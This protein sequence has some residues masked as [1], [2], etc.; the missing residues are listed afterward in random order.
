MGRKLFVG[1]LA[2]ATTDESLRKAFEKFGSLISANVIMDRETGRSRGFGFVVFAE[3]SQAQAA[4]N[5]MQGSDVDGRRIRVDMAT[6]G[7][8][9][10]ARREGGGRFGGDRPHRE[11]LPYPPV[12]RRGGS[13]EYPPRREW[14]AP[15]PAA[16]PPPRWEGGE[17]EGGK[18]RAT[19][20]RNEKK[21]K[22]LRGGDVERDWPRAG[23]RLKREDR[24]DWEGEGEDE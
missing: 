18:D 10:G 3:D 1:G 8:G 20:R 5:A 17:G 9:G 23:K 21:R 14:S 7:P 15:P 19:R 4:L 2:W 11:P 16:E 12:E 6:E 24:W 22:E 13:G